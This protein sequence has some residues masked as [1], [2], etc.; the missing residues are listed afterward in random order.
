MGNTLTAKD[1]ITMKI[2]KFL[3]FIFI[4]SLFISLTAHNLQACFLI[5]VVSS[6]T[7][8]KAQEEVK[9]AKTILD[10]AKQELEDVR[11]LNRFRGK[12]AIGQVLNRDKDD[13]LLERIPDDVE[14]AEGI[15]ARREKLQAAKD[16]VADAQYIYD[17]ALE[18]WA[19]CQPVTHH[20]K[21][22]PACGDDTHIVNMCDLYMLNKFAHT[23]L[24]ASC[25][26]KNDNQEQCSV[27]NFYICQSHNHDFPSNSGS[28]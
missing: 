26:I 7:K 16:K 4:T 3:S 10:N 14:K 25:P 12:I 13:S 27:T 17:K 2:R 20:V 1:F 24:Q 6:E 11:E 5:E 8:A 28:R 22:V 9:K 19:A 23:I 21:F 15:L 18:A